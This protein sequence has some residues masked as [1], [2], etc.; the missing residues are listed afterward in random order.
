MN[1]LDDVSVMI[2]VSTG[3]DKN[4]M[5]TADFEIVPQSDRKTGR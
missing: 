3:S 5:M 1:I 4:S 2:R